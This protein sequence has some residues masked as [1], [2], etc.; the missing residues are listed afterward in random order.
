MDNVATNSPDFPPPLANRPHI[1]IC[2]L[3]RVEDALLALELGASFLGVIMTAKSSR[4]VDEARAA[5][6]L[7]Q[8]REDSSTPPRVIGVFTDEHPEHIAHLLQTLNL[9]AV[10]IHAPLINHS[11]HLAPSR[12]IP[13][14]NI[15]TAEDAGRLAQQDHVHEAVLADAFSPGARGGTGKVFD[16]SLVQGLYSR[17]RV[18]LAGGISPDNIDDILASHPGAYPYA[19]D[20]SSGVEESPGIKSHDKL[21]NFFQKFNAAVAR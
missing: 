7:R 2:G 10:Q 14:V 15:R 1:K 4:F 16:H 19:I 5:N 17:R 12:I 8:L 13:A 18:F 21:R 6:L 20:L 11:K 9:F 3:T